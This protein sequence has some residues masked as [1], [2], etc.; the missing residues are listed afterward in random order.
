MSSCN[1][2][3]SLATILLGSFLLAGHAGTEQLSAEDSALQVSL[4]GEEFLDGANGRQVQRAYV[5]SGT[6]QIA[7]TVPEGFRADASDPQT[8]VLSDVNYTCFITFR[9]AGSMPAGATELQADS[10][11]NTALSR[12]PGAKI[13]DEFSECAANHNGPAFD[14]QWTNSGGTEQSARVVFLP[15]TAGVIEFTLLASAKNFPDGR[16][17]F[18]TLLASL[19]NN[20]GGKLIIT[21][22]SGQS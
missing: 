18:K 16:N 2:V 6:N 4:K 11:R 12:F 3:H 13:S 15:S 7:F 9:F 20:E 22:L 17:I 1:P 8:I 19:R 10:Y 14:L 5:T 21:R